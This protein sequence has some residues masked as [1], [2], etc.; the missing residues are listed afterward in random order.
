MD[1]RA[2]VAAA[3]AAVL[4]AFSAALACAADPSA[5]AEAWKPRA[6]QAPH[7]GDALF[8][9]FQDRH[10]GA[11]TALMVSQHFGRVAPHDDESE[12]LRGGLLLNYGLH[13]E[14]GEVFAQLIARNAPAAVRDRAWYFV[15]RMRHQRGLVAEAEDALARVGGPLP[16]A[17]EG[18]HQL[19][20]ALL[21]V[22]RERHADA[23]A[24]LEALQQRKDLPAAAAMVARFNLGVALVRLGDTARG[25]QLL[26]QV[27]QTPSA[28]E[29]QRALRDRA[30]VALGFAMLQARQPR[31]ARGALQRVRLNAAS[32]NKALLG[33]GW[34]AAEL[35]DP[36]LALVPWTELAARDIGDAAVLEAR[37]AVPYAY[38]ELGAYATA[39]RHYEQAVA[40]FERERRALDESIA[41]VR[42]GTLLA[43]LL[44]RNAAAGLGAADGVATLPDSAAVPHR[45]H[46]LALLA[47]H[48]FQE[49]FKN[50]HDLHFLQRNLQHWQ[51]SLSAF[52]DL[53]D[54]RRRAYAERLPAVQEFPRSGR[55]AALQQRRDALAAELARAE[56]ERD[57]AAFA[58]DG[59]RALLERIER[60]REVLVRAAAPGSEAGAGLA[61]PAHL[62]DAGDRLRRAAGALTWQLMQAL[63]SRSWDAKKALRDSEQG[64]AEVAERDAAL[65]RA[66]Q[67]EPLRHDAFGQ[68]IGELG[69]R[70]A[71]L[72]GPLQQTELAQRALLQGLAV[73]ELQAQQ[74]RLDQYTAQARLAIAQILDRAQVASSGPGAA[75]AMR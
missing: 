49:A 29:E 25:E 13:R 32:S 67:S 18:E 31:E 19:L 27:G 23:A 53:L 4:A 42:A 3:A 64:L 43:A 26:A 14:A 69:T 28:D 60:G 74:Q 10:F 70:I 44:E 57:A 73:A 63:P 39:L 51:A 56:A 75:G 36:K 35:K 68:R 55:I 34:A 52:D 33:Y 17:L 12:L 41:A 20:R 16:G 7:Y 65:A 8:H 47:G 71:A 6:V 61:D 48:G 21:L 66:Q 24:L 46:L 58:N 72:M 54:S 30:N 62:A 38:G 40:D 37:I 45:G 15:A 2:A 11:L 50:L 9:F 1:L 22:A 5:A 59:E